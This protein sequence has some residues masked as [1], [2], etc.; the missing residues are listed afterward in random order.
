MEPFIRPAR[1]DDIP[2]VLALWKAARSHPSGTDDAASLTR[3]IRHDPGAL[4]V[5]DDDGAI[6]GSVI[7]AWDGWRGSV[8]R[9]AVGSA[10]RRRGLASA[11]VAEA[12]KRLRSVGAVR[13]QAT[14]VADDL[15]AMGFWSAG[16]WQHAAAQ[17][18]FTQSL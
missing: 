17:T 7:A 2:A 10:H 6:A 5:A 18:R 16:S 1:S 13:L 15:V 9:L 3:L 11:L 8:Y 12:E 4:L 14:V